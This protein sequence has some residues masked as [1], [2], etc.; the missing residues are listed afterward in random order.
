M[1]PGLSL[2]TERGIGLLWGPDC[3]EEFLKKSQLK[4]IYKMESA[5]LGFRQLNISLLARLQLTCWKPI[6]CGIFCRC[7][8]L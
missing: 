7:Y 5:F 3:T 8:D 1:D 4:V 6:C 2:N